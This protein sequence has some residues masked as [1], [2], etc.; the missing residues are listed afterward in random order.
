[1]TIDHVFV[2]FAL[3]DQY[4]AASKAAVQQYLTAAADNAAGIPAGGITVAGI[5]ADLL[6]S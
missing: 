1:L 5:T 6:H 4:T 3:G 2:E